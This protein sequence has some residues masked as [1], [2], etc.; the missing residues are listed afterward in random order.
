MCFA[1]FLN[2]EFW[3][4]LITTTLGVALGIPAALW[5]ERQIEGEKEKSER[6]E[7]AQAL[8]DSLNKNLGL[9]DQLARE[10]A[11]DDY[12]PLYPVDLTI[13]DATASRK[14]ELLKK[15]D[16]VRAIDHAR[17]ELIHLNGKLGLMRNTISGLD[18]R[19][20]AFGF[21]L[22]V[23]ESI[24][25]HLPTVKDAIQSAAQSLQ[26]EKKKWECD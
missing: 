13:L 8:L 9:V 6:K 3:Q 11:Q 14:Y 10:L 18:T 5:I 16:V 17:F 2:T 25:Q 7:L 21:Y 23:R 19:G 26:N 12:V 22:K 15:S 20:Q 24:K 4:Q 1:S